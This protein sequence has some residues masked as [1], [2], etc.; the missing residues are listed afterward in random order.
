MKYTRENSNHRTSTNPRQ[1]SVAQ[2]QR[3]RKDLGIMT[4]LCATTEHTTTTTTG[5]VH[6]SREFQFFFWWHLDSLLLLAKIVDFFFFWILDPRRPFA[7]LAMARDLGDQ[8]Q[9]AKF[10]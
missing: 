4:L 3:R 2:S 9:P 8:L 1:I 6:N 7:L 5:N 10:H